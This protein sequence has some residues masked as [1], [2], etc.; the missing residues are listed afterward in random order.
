M[1]LYAGELFS[2]KLNTT[3]ISSD[4]RLGAVSLLFSA[5]APDAASLTGASGSPVRRSQ[6]VLPRA[7]LDKGTFVPLRS[8]G[9]VP[10]SRAVIQAG[11]TV[12]C[13]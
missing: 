4:S 2:E 7:T 3:Q 13:D 8:A 1:M 10:Q 5:H 12:L 9:V 6:Q 11:E